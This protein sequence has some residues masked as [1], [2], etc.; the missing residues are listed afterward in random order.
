MNI[1]LRPVDSSFEQLAVDVAMASLDPVGSIESGAADHQVTAKLDVG[2]FNIPHYNIVKG[3]IFLAWD[4][5]YGSFLKEINGYRGF[6]A[7]LYLK[8]Q[9]LTNDTGCMSL[10]GIEET[11][12]LQEIKNK[13]QDDMLQIEFVEPKSVAEKQWRYMQ[14]AISTTTSGNTYPQNVTGPATY[15]LSTSTS[16]DPFNTWTP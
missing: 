14:G 1:G 7:N 12:K 3:F 9:S 16:V 13:G 10:A 11:M 5:K 2:D 15:E 4:K 8:L 6:D